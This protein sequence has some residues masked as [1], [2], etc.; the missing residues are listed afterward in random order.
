[1]GA[2]YE[3]VHLATERRRALKV[4]LPHC[5]Q[6]NE[7]RERFAREARV[8]SQIESEY[9]VDVSDAGVDESTQMPFL[10]MELLRG[11]EME[12]R[13]GRAG[14]FSPGEAVTYLHQVAMALDRTHQALIVHRDL[15]PANLFLTQREDGTPRVKI[16]DFGVAKVVAES[17]TAAGATR[18]LGTPLYMSP[19]QFRSGTKLTPAADIYALGLLSYTMLVGEPYWSREAREAGDVIAFAMVAVRGPAESAVRRAAARHVA[20]PAS[21]DAWFAKATAVSPANRFATASEAVRTL[22][23]VLGLSQGLGAAGAP[24]VPGQTS[25]ESFPSFN[26]ITPSVTP[27][28]L[29]PM[30]TSTSSAVA[31]VRK[32]QGKGALVAT[33]ATLGVVVLGAGVFVAMRPGRDEPVAPPAAAIGPAT[34][35]MAATAAT[36]ATVSP[37]SEV[38]G[39]SSAV[40]VASASPSASASALR[41]PSPV[42]PSTAPSVQAGAS[43]KASPGARPLPQATGNKT[44]TT[45]APPNSLLGRD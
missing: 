1:M 45:T 44:K 25:R 33:I 28:A 38:A 17:A 20:L 23:E 22:A 7:M 6:S 9:I 19:E 4:L 35:A 37:G 13:L 31:P 16:L 5:F 30:G 18:S 2:V 12:H 8:T 14:R 26:S 42:P 24:G 36:A 27:P 40:V 32:E 21:F 11:E 43:A 10:V 34:D 29:S 3:A 41:A 39:G 15:K